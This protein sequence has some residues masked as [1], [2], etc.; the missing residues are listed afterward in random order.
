MN[1]IYTYLYIHARQW[2]EVSGSVSYDFPLVICIYTYMYICIHVHKY[3]HI[4]V[5]IYICK[6]IYVAL[7]LCFWVCGTWFPINYIY[8]YIYTYTNIY[9]NVYTNIYTHARDTDC[10][11]G[12]RGRILSLSHTH[13]HTWQG[14]LTKMW[15]ADPKARPAAAHCLEALGINSQKSSC[16]SI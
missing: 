12:R 11:H 7:S 8:T 15:V 14:L 16:C 10:W 4:H 3:I 5:Y 9:T 1:D 6:F 13:T 2:A